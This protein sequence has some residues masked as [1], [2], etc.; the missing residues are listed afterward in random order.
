MQKGLWSETTRR[1]CAVISRGTGSIELPAVEPTPRPNSTSRRASEPAS[2]K[3]IRTVRQQSRRHT[4]RTRPTTRT[5]PRLVPSLWLISLF[6]SCIRCYQRKAWTTR[7]AAVATYEEYKRL[8]SQQVQPTLG[9]CLTLPAIPCRRSL[10]TVKLL[11]L[12]T[13]IYDLTSC[14]HGLRGRK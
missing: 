4:R 10:P 1:L 13:T 6:F 12:Y 14:P 11:P 3:N 8:R 2:E 9:S 7:S 5:Q